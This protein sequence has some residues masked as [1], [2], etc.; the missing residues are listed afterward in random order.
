MVEAK[1][2]SEEVLKSLPRV[3]VCFRFSA[4]DLPLSHQRFDEVK[5][6]TEHYLSS[7]TVREQVIACSSKLSGKKDVAIILKKGDLESFFTVD[8]DYPSEPSLQI[9][10]SLATEFIDTLYRQRGIVDLFELA[11]AQLV[12]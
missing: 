5:L 11:V 7:S 10:W 6:V 4:D 8:D 3:P 12:C 2:I 1:M 9:E